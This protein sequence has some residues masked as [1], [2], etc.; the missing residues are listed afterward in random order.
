VCLICVEYDKDRLT[1]KEAWNNL[2]EMYYSL[3]PDHRTEIVNKLMD[4]AIFGEEEIDEEL[5]GLIF[6]GILM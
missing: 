2:G 4:E 5:W 6:Q 1:I 3:E